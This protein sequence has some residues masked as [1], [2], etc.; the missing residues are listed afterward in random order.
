MFQNVG[1][2]SQ[3]RAWPI[4][5]YVGPNG[6][7]KSACMVW[8][9]LPSLEAGRRVL[10]TVRL[11]DYRHP[12]TCPGCSEPGHRRFVYGGAQTLDDVALL[13]DVP[14]A[15]LDGAMVQQVYEERPVIGETIH[16]KAHP[17]YVRL[18]DWQQVL[19]AGDCD[20]LFDEVTGVASSR[21]S[22]GLPAAVANL[23]VQLRRA[24]VVL[25]WT[26]PDWSRADVIIRQC[27]QAVTHCQGHL[28]KQS[29]DA[30]RLWR[31]RRLFR[32]KT[33]DATMFDDFTSGKREALSPWVNDWHWGPKSPAFGAYDT[34]DSVSV[35]GTVSESGTCY[36]CGGT[37]RRPACSCA[38]T[39]V[40][41]SEAAGV[42]AGG[43]EGVRESPAAPAGRR[44]L[45]LS[46]RE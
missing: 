44:I 28:P 16:Q 11:L 32:W 17:L 35:V 38:K 1:K 33:Y 37:R 2:R 30:D 5:G 22:M 26:A 20:V 8:D 40:A 31:Q 14:V 24:D 12:Q 13:L 9:T 36:R 41:L 45:D 18:A 23:L 15:E 21:E 39:P 3:R 25:R 29:G 34:F 46:V 42:L 4:H 10:S 19:D 27:S 43:P 6:A 7:G